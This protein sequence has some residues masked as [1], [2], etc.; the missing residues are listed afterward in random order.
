MYSKL[1][2]NTKYQFKKFKDLRYDDFKSLK[3]LS[4][5]YKV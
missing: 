1:M 5:F 3:F 4:V 2:G